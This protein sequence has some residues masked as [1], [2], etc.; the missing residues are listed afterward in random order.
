MSATESPRSDKDFLARTVEAAIRIGL[1]FVLVLWCFQ[2]V[3]PFIIPV[4]WGI[5]LAVA[6]HPGYERLN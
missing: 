1:I 3:K 6:V 5:V 4:I 2:I